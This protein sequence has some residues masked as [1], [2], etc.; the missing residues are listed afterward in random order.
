MRKRSGFLLFFGCSACSLNLHDLRSKMRKHSSVV[1]TAQE[2][3]CQNLKY[4]PAP[5]CIIG[6]E[7][8][9]RHFQFFGCSSL[10]NSNSN[11][12]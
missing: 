10:K 4:K 3:H 11:P 7:I 2:P 9:F 6:A 1:G 5:V 8:L 12:A